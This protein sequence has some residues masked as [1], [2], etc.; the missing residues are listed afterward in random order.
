LAVSGSKPALV[1]RIIAAKKCAKAQ[2]QGS[3]LL[4]KLSREEVLALQSLEELVYEVSCG[5]D[6]L[7]EFQSHLA[8]HKS[9]E[10]YASKELEDLLDNKAIVTADYKMKILSCFFRE[11]QKKWF[12]KGG[13]S[14]LGF[15][16]TV[17]RK[18]PDK[19]AKGMKDVSF[20]MM[21][22]E[23]ALQDKHEVA[24]A[25]AVLYSQYLPEHIT[26]VWFV[27]DGAGCF[28]SQ[29]HQAF[30]PFWKIWTGIDKI[31]YQITPAGDRKLNLDGMFGRLN[32]VLATS[33]NG[34]WSYYNSETVCKPLKN[35]MGWQLQSFLALSP[36]N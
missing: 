31:S 18:D 30:Q 12:G 32:T 24:C 2:E 33:V 34:G 17:N 35:Q 22:T 21:V 1:A 7:A 14:M 10:E 9:E 23:D 26:K 15:M 20:V 6:D 8:H 16:I 28:K 13:T 29:F 4:R 27:L 3:V 5:K 25:K 36:S 11:N 19:K